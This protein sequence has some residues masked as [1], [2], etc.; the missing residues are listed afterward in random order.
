M[1]D[2]LFQ[3]TC[4]ICGNKYIEG[5][6]FKC[7]DCYDKMKIERKNFQD[8]RYELTVKYIN[9]CDDNIKNKLLAQLLIIN[10]FYP[11]ELINNN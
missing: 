3:S 6:I 11:K 5:T 7:K 10:D 8:K 2:F 1:F 9:E 4:K